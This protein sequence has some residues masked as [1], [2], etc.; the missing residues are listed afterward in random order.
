MASK[1]RGGGPSPGLVIT[2]VFFVLA[3]IGLGISTYFGF[4][5]QGELE[6]EAK[7]KDKEKAAFQAQRD[8]YKRQAQVYRTYMTGE[9]PVGAKI[10][11]VAQNRKALEE[12]KLGEASVDK[13][14]KDDVGTF[15]KNTLSREMPWVSD[16]EGPPS[17]YKSRLEEKDKAIAALE[18]ANRQLMELLATAQKNE[19]DA[20]VRAEDQKKI[21]QDA[22]A[23]VDAKVK[24]HRDEY[25]A[26][27]QNRA[28]ALKE[29]GE[30]LEEARK[31]RTVAL[32]ERDALK[33][34]RNK[35]Q[36]DLKNANKRVQESKLAHAALESQLKALR[37]RG[38]NVE[39][40]KLLA[41][42]Q[43]AKAAQRLKEWTKNWKVVS[44]ERVGTVEKPRTYAYINLGSNHRVTPGLTFSV[45]AEEANG[46]LAAV[47]KGTLEVV[48]VVRPELALALVTSERDV[49]GDPISRR[50][51]LFNAVWDPTDRRRV[52][53]AGLIDLSGDGSEGTAEFLRKLEREGTQVDAYL[54]LTGKEPTV[55]G[56]VT[57]QTDYLIVGSGLEGTR[58]PKAGDANFR[59]RTAEA[60]TAMRDRALA[61]GVTL[62]DVERY[63]QMT[64]AGPRSVARPVAD[65]IGAFR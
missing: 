33:A 9:P 16:K 4:A 55:R 35:L 51:R 10:E 50:D 27:Q 44:V 8:W 28:E 46:K 53:V 30:K 31:Q 34:E 17:T 1:K 25:A 52:A 20:K 32:A 40:E 45:H 36:A 49:K 18:A 57:A 15:L 64:G 39:D 11:E 42:V 59:K 38:V 3:T 7:A 61:Q 2:L 65:G 22:V 37:A 19:G 41:E 26:M 56:A 23:E 5:S 24:K 43:A 13:A 54:D 14:E 21:S 62:I 47:P 58:H 12:G 60:I 29:A 6:K 63:R 48:R